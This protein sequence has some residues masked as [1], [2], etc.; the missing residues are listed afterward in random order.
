MMDKQPLRFL[1]LTV[2]T[3]LII[4]G[5]SIQKLEFFLYL[6]HWTL[7][8]KTL[9]FLCFFRE[10]GSENF[11]KVLLSISWT[12]GLNVTILYWAYAYPL[13][14]SP[15]FE[16]WHLILTHG[17]VFLFLIPELISSTI[18]FVNK[19]FLGPACI[20][21][22]YMFCVVIPSAYLGVII[23]PGLTFTNLLSYIVVIANFCVSFGA[24]SIGKH[25]CQKFMKSPK[26]L[27]KKL[28]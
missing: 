14:A 13:T 25:I 22:V 17:G 16:L 8:A 11:R 18:T 19:D 23:Y 10:L 24:F 28:E 21:A 6:T 26:E 20:S 9:T 2:C 3:F 7:L 15:D 27:S 12:M 4:R 1:A 5:I